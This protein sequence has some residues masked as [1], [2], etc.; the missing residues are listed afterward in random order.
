MEVQDRMKQTIKAMRESNAIDEDK[1]LTY[2]AAIDTWI[3]SISMLSERIAE[4]ESE[5]SVKENLLKI[6]NGLIGK[7]YFPCE[8]AKTMKEVLNSDAEDIQDDA[9][10]F[11][12]EYCQKCIKGKDRKKEFDEICDMFNDYME[13]YNKN[14][15]IRF[16]AELTQKLRESGVWYTV[17]SF[18][19]E[20]NVK[21]IE[22]GNPRKIT[23]RID[24]MPKGYTAEKICEIV[25]AYE[26]IKHCKEHAGEHLH[27]EEHLKIISLRQEI[28]CLKR[29]S[30]KKDE[31]IKS[32]KSKLDESAEGERS[33]RE[34]LEK[35]EAEKRESK[36][37]MFPYE[38]MEKMKEKISELNDRH[39]SDCI[40]KTQLH[41]ALDVMAE[42]YQRLR[43]IHG[44]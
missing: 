38:S 35:L 7:I 4:L 39:Q 32:L 41:T 42:K 12:I 3:E 2:V 34:E 28:D 43:E 13:E 15:V 40:E 21:D 26:D 1:Y 44:L 20:I 11:G 24:G 29:N 8:K 22:V 14:G 27:S 17:E 36:D 25:R 10:R 9:H 5:L 19:G 18:D 16:L 30:S 37:K 6:K 33:L 31:L 23:V